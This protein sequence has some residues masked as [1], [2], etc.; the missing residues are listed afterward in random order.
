MHCGKQHLPIHA[1]ARPD[2][3]WTCRRIQRAAL[4]PQFIEK[5][6]NLVMPL[7]HLLMSFAVVKGSSF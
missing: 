4:L 1:R 5:Q 2:H 6:H 3:T 7:V